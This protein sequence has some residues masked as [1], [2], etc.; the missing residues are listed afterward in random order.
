VDLDLCE[1]TGMCVLAAPEVFDLDDAPLRYDAEPDESLHE[2]VADA[3]ASCPVMA[4]TMT[5]GPTDLAPGGGE[6]A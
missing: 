3:V 1:S 5:S 6:P 4:I 2:D